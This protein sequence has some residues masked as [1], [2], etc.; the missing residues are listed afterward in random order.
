MYATSY[1]VAGGLISVKSQN[2]FTRSIYAWVSTFITTTNRIHLLQEQD[3]FGLVLC[4]Q[5]QVFMTFC[6][7]S[8]S[9]LYDF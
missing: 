9:S 3:M 1:M 6:S 2:M 5:G 7:G 4:N 8:R